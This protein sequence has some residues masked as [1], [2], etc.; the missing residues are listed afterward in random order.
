MQEYSHID[1]RERCCSKALWSFLLIG[2]FLY[3]LLVSTGG[4]TC[5]VPT[6]KV[7]CMIFQVKTYV[8]FP[9][10]IEACSAATE[11]N[12]NKYT[13]INHLFHKTS[14]YVTLSG[15]LYLN[16]RRSCYYICAYK[17]FIYY[18][19]ITENVIILCSPLGK[20]KTILKIAVLPTSWLHLTSRNCDLSSS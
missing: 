6:W 1:I 12:G 14:N 17:D 5:V 7:T 2:L 18:L 3:M 10:F 9:S 19:N 15:N 11:M 13:L 4:S 20:W 8:Y 16:I